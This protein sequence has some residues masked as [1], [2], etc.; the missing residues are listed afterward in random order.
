MRP[1][2][3]SSRTEEAS[4]GSEQRLRDLK[5][6]LRAIAADSDIPAPERAARLALL[7]GDLLSFTAEA[8]AND[9]SFGRARGRPALA[10]AAEWREQI[11]EKGLPDEAEVAAD[12][13][14]EHLVEDEAGDWRER[15]AEVS[16]TGDAA[17]CFVVLLEAGVRDRE[18]VARR[19]DGSL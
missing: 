2:D 5:E 11:S 18:A 6:R 19:S 7:E 12:H 14:V 16:R 13:L 17:A 4:S 10:W 8:G 3:D 1:D 9:P 15:A